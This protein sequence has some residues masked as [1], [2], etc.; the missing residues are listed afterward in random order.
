MART[1]VKEEELPL[2]QEVSRHIGAMRLLWLP[3][4]DLPGPSSLRGVIERNSIALLSNYRREALDPPSPGWLGL[5]SD[6]ERVVRSGLWNNNHVD[7]G[8]EPAFLDVLD[9]LIQHV[10]IAT[11]FSLFE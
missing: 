9:D 11:D 5:Y 1:A 8:Y 6:R 2:E 4:D 7:E 10:G 3:I